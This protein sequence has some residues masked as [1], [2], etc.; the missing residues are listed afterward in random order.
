[1]ARKGNMKKFIVATIKMLF[2]LYDMFI[3][4]LFKLVYGKHGQ[5]MPPIKNV[6]LLESATSLAFKIRNKKVSFFFN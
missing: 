3:H 2:A 4:N 1:M 5:K 6:I